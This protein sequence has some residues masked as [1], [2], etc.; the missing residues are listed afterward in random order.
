MDALLLMVTA[1]FEGSV[2][3]VPD[4]VKSLAVNAVIAWLKFATT[5]VGAA[6][7]NEVAGVKLVSVG[8]D[9]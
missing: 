9:P 4:I 3:Q 5:L 1:P 6:V 8:A 7:K 2:V